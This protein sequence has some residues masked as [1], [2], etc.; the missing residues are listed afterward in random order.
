MLP[1][2]PDVE[3]AVLGPGGLV[4]G[5]AAGTTYIDMSTIDPAT[6]QR[7]GAG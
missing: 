2:S 6:T 4:E 1:D 5:M 3:K 7:I